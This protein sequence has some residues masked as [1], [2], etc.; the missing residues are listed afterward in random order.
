M[1]GLVLKELQPVKKF[2]VLDWINDKKSFKD[3]CRLHSPEF[4][5]PS[6]VIKMRGK[7][8]ELYSNPQLLIVD[9]SPVISMHLLAKRLSS[10]LDTHRCEAGRVHLKSG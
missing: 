6:E 1:L 5:N 3:F 8:R 10:Y 9:K 2:E 7:I 4:C